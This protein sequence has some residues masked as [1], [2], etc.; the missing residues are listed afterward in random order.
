MSEPQ[1]YTQLFKEPNPETIFHLN[2]QDFKAFLAYVF[3]RAGFYVTPFQHAGADLELKYEGKTI[4]Y[5]GTSAGVANVGPNPVLALNGLAD[6]EVDAMRYFISSGHF[7]H[8]ATES[9][10]AMKNIRLLDIDKLRR[11]IN[12]IRGTRHPK[13]KGSPIDPVQIFD[14]EPVKRSTTQTKVLALANNKGG[15]SKTTSAFA[16]ALILAAEKHRRVLLVDVDEQ[17]NLTQAALGT[18]SYN[19]PNIADYFVQTATLGQLV[20]QTRFDN[21]W[22]IPSHPDLRLTLTNVTNW[23]KT[24]QRFASALHHESVAPPGGEVFDWI[25]I[26]T[27]PALSLHTRSA[28]TAAHYVLTPFTPTILGRIGLAMLLETL[29][30]I[31]GLA[32][33]INQTKMLGCFAT[34]WRST[35]AIKQEVA[36]MR[37]IALQA[38][39]PLF[40]AEIEDDAT[41]IRKLVLPEGIPRISTIHGAFDDYRKLVK[42]ILEHVGDN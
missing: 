35:S 17:A 38:G 19:L 37:A 14:N 32:S 33:G 28:L 3:E 10:K 13:S 29:S 20:Q 26:D 7:A 30:D 25:I 11:F 2:G 16:I 1:D 18:V 40:E 5:I 42:E 12:Y 31:S 9:A 39:S 34:R 21:I 41:N 27:P 23:T 8:S 22:I 4:A 15:A 36:N 24:E 6:A